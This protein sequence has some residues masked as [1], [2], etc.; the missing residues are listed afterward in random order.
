MPQTT[1]RHFEIT[2]SRAQAK[3]YLRGPTIL[4]DPEE[5]SLIIQKCLRPIVQRAVKRMLRKA[6]KAYPH[7]LWSQKTSVSPKVIAAIYTNDKSVRFA[8]F[9]SQ[10]HWPPHG[11]GS[12]I[13][14][15]S[16]RQ[17]PYRP[18]APNRKGEARDQRLKAYWAAMVVSKLGT[19]PHLLINRIIE[20]E[21]PKVLREINQVVRSILDDKPLVLS[22]DG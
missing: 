2:D 8:E 20:E 1:Y 13:A 21:R 22:E 3:F 15:W 17:T 19:K 18:I 10:P 5:V 4:Q 16:H 12:R 6:K 11:E 14:E 9:G 7:A